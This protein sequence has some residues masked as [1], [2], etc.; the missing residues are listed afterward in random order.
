MDHLTSGGEVMS[1]ALARQVKDGDWSA[2][3]RLSP[4]PAAAL[5]QAQLTQAP[6]ARSLWP[7]VPIGPLRGSGR[8]SLTRPRPEGSIC[9][10]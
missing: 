3:G 4:M 8:G 10:M 1:A 5:W 7:G 9:F 6:R 2:G